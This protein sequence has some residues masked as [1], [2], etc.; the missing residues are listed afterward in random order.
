MY[1]RT[2]TRVNMNTSTYIICAL[3]TRVLVLHM[4]MVHVYRFY[5]IIIALYIYI[6][7]I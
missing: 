1:V 2:C 4:R 3:F 5:V 7:K 6:A